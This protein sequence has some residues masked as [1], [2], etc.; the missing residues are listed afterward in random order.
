MKQAGYYSIYDGICTVNYAYEEDGVIY[1]ADLIKVSVALDTGKLTGL[2]ARNYLMNHKE[3]SLPQVSL[4]KQEAEGMLMSGLGVLDC[5][6]AV[7]PLDTGK[8]AYCYELHCRDKD[9]KEMLI[10]INALTG[11]QEDLL[12]LLYSDGGVLTK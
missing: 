7:I 2:D 5:R 1:Y 10:Y 6:L 3:R 12:I 9:K 4:D 11:K 8:E